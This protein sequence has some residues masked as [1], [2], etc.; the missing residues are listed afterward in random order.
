MSKIIIWWLS[1]N[2]GSENLQRDVK[3]LASAVTPL[4]DLRWTS[5][6]LEPTADNVLMRYTCRLLNSVQGKPSYEIFKCHKLQNAHS[7]ADALEIL[8]VRDE[9]CAQNENRESKGARERSLSFYQMLWCGHFVSSK[10]TCRR[11][12]LLLSAN[13]SIVYPTYTIRK[14]TK[15]FPDRDSF[16][17][18]VWFAVL[19][20][21]LLLHAYP[22]TSIGCSSCTGRWDVACTSSVALYQRLLCLWSTCC[23]HWNL[24]TDMNAHADSRQRQAFCNKEVGS[25]GCNYVQRWG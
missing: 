5:D 7:D 16:L 17:R 4:F 14:E 23:T 9:K 2:C 13:G 25:K 8:K 10:C 19:A 11:Y 24:L 1:P 21:G 15:L 18:Y 6:V 3:Y 20:V 12:N 22:I